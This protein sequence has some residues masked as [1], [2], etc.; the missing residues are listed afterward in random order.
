MGAAPGVQAVGF[1]DELGAAY[2]ECRFAVVPLLS[3]AGTNIKV[4]EA[5]RF[6]RACV[7]T[8]FSHRGFGKTLHHDEEVLVAAGDDAFV[9]ACVELL[10]SPERCQ[11]LARQGRSAVARHYSFAAFSRTVADSIAK[12]LGA[13][14]P[15][16]P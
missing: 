3:G 13:R 16:A 11:T 4:M 1:V 2:A 15:P 8:E 14:R 12:L 10:D 5:L 6:G 9:A 7:L